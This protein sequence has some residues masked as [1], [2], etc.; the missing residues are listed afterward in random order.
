MIQQGFLVG[1]NYPNTTSQ[2]HGCV[3][4]AVRTLDAIERFGF[5]AEE[6]TLAVDVVPTTNTTAWKRARRVQPTKTEIVAELE[7]LAALSQQHSGG[8][9]WVCMSG[10]GMQRS[11]YDVS[12][13]LDEVF[14]TGDQNYICDT[15][16]SLIL[17]KFHRD[18][19]VFWLMDT[20]H[21]STV[22][23][24]T[25]V[26]GRNIACTVLNVS[27]CTD[28]GVSA[29]SYDSYYKEAAGAL[30]SCWLAQLRGVQPTDKIEV[31]FGKL[32]TAMIA[33]GYT[34]KP[35]LHLHSGAGS[36]YNRATSFLALLQDTVSLREDTAQ[37][38]KA[39]HFAEG[40][41]PY[42][43]WPHA[44]LIALGYALHAARYSFRYNNAMNIRRH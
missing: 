36:Q 41:Q 23:D 10:H 43:S 20:C 44:T 15:E 1:C 13:R 2:L 12:D 17:G 37:A 42:E 30:T 29:D 39:V 21:S 8:K 35:Q 27:G 16:F 14:Y 19:V 7:R 25:E 5:T 3:N 26:T 24:L 38:A 32:E 11:G 18:S 6:C 4:D 9:Y 22:L 31:L 33:N 40:V 34:Q 28:T